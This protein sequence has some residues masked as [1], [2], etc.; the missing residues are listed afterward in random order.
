M[1]HETAITDMEM[2]ALEQQVWYGVT[3]TLFLLTLYYL[4]KSSK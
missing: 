3:W 4:F 1:N 2:W